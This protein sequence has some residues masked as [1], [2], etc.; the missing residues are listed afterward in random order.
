MRRRCWRN[1]GAH[2]PQRSRS[3]QEG[4]ERRS[5]TSSKPRC[6]RCSTRARRIQTGRARCAG[7]RAAS[8]TIGSTSSSPRCWR[9][10]AWNLQRRSTRPWSGWTAA[11]CKTLRQMLAEWV[12]FRQATITRAASTAQQGAGTHPRPR[13]PA[14]G[15]AEHRRGDRHHPRERQAKAALIARFS[16]C[17]AAA[18]TTSSRSPAPAGARLEAIKI[19]AG[20]S[21]LRAPSRANLEDIPGQRATSSA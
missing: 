18:P 15:A 20:L 10:P 16:I 2:Q 21:D 14:A 12:A 8:R 1:R 7:V 19:R 9:T 4:A 6:S 11:R 3:R 5:K 13:R 17:R